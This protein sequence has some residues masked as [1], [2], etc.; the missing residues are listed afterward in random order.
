MVPWRT[1][2]TEKSKALLADV[3]KL[4]GNSVY[5]KMI[6]A[7]ER[8]TNVIYTKHER[9]VGQALRSPYFSD[10]DEVGQAYE[11][12]SQKPRIT[13]RRPF[14]VGI[15]VYQPRVLLQLSQQIHQQGGFRAAPDGHGQPLHGYLCRAA[16]G[17]RKAAAARRVR[18]GEEK[19]VDR[20]KNSIW[21][22]NQQLFTHE[23]MLWPIA[24]EIHDKL[25]RFDLPM[26]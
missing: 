25:L 3:F 21:R 9:I 15:L 19:L 1:G 12:E 20:G 14:Q 8:Q 24:Q 17:H 22:D 7:L 11:L 13:I 4:L 10:L 26:W 16:R 5:G 2:D 18:G 23:A 6:E